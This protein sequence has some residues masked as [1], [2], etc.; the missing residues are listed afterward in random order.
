MTHIG[1]DPDTHGCGVAIDWGY[2]GGQPLAAFL[3]QSKARTLAE[4]A[5]EMSNNLAAHVARLP[6]FG[7]VFLCIEGQQI[8]RSE[9][10]KGDP[11]DILKLAVVTGAVLGALGTRMAL[12]DIELPLPRQWKGGL[13]KKEHHRR[14]ARDFPHWVEPV[15]R[16][17]TDSL[18]HHVWDAVGLLEW[19][20]T[21][22]ERQAHHG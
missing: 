20:R 19:H 13:P 7:R 12:E 6:G 5:Q 22:L 8:Y 9:R 2:G 17:T 14:L 16:D 21:R 4:R 10:S 3:L 18:Q 11:N 15:K 1:V